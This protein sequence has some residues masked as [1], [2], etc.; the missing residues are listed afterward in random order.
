M[1]TPGYSHVIITISVYGS[2]HD[3]KF[4]IERLSSGNQWARRIG[5]CNH[6]KLSFSLV[7]GSRASQLEISFGDNSCCLKQHDGYYR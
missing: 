6:M 4:T 2:S 7:Q 1:L 3:P 5:L